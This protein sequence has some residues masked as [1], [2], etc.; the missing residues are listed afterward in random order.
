MRR[1]TRR[2]AICVAI[3]T[4]PITTWWMVGDLSEGPYAQ[5]YMFKA[6]T[7][8]RNHQLVVGIVATLLLLVSGGVLVAAVAHRRLS[9][10]NVRPAVPLL[11]AGAF[12]G[13][14]ARVMTARVSGANIGGG[15]FM[16]LGP[17]V[18]LGAIAWSW[19]FARA[20]DE[21]SSTRH[22]GDPL[23]RDERP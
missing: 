17:L 14:A 21:G 11:L 6:P 7:L 22:P 12:S 20:S 18:L 2:L 23:G 15:L 8:A 4:L 5:D 1:A 13:W 19:Y 10:V 9:W 16:L 3:A